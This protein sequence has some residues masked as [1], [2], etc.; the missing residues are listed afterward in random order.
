MFV[1]IFLGGKLLNNDKDYRVPIY[2]PICKKRLF[3]ILTPSEG[4]IEIK[5]P[6]CKQI[7]VVNLKTKQRTVE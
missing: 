6:K 1:I 3:D 5:C 2:C 4:I 7:I